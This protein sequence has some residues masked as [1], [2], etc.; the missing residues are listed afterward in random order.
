MSTDLH[1]VKNRIGEMNRSLVALTELKDTVKCELSLPLSL[2]FSLPP[3]LCFIILPSIIKHA[4]LQDTVLSLREEVEEL[5]QNRE[6][7]ASFVPAKTSQL[8]SENQE[9]LRSLSA[10]QVS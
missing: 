6:S 5:K 1:R 9:V 2:S 8:E 4:A 7:Y 10:D 3:P